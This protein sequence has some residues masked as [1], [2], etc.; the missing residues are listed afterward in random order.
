VMPGLSRVTT[1]LVA[2]LVGVVYLALLVAT[3]EIGPADL[4]MLRALVSKRGA[5]KN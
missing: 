3:R 2:L 1:P 4:S 5:A